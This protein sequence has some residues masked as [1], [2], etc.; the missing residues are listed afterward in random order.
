MKKLFGTD[1]IRGVANVPPMTAEMALDIGRAA[2]QVCRRHKNRRSK[3]IVGRD[4]RRSGQMLESALTAGICSMGVDV[5]LVGCVTTPG[6]AFLTRSINADAGIVVSASHNPYQDNGIK[7]FSHDGYKLPDRGEDEIER[8]VVTKEAK[9][10]SEAN[11]IGTTERIT[12]A[13]GRYVVFC[14]STFPGNLTLEGMKITIDCANG[15]AY[16]AAPM[17]FSELGAEVTPI[18][19]EPDGMNINDHCGSQDTRR[20]S[21]KVR[22]LS[23]DLGL[24]FDGDGDRIIAVDE[25]GREI[26]GDCILAIC[27]KMYKDRGWLRNNLVISTVMSNYGLSLA[28]KKLAIDNASSDV[29]DRNVLEKM[30]EKGAVVGGEPSGHLIFLNHHTSGDGII[31]AL[32][33][34][35]AIRL[36]NKPLSRL[37]LVM[38]QTPQKII[39]VDVT[40]KPP[41]GSIPGLREAVLAAETELDSRGRVLIRYSGTQSVCRVMVEG[42]T[43][44]MT[45]RL[46]HF[47]AERV[48]SR[49][50]QER[51]RRR[52]P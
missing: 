24:A 17:V 45:D 8:L 18:N 11:R 33:L 5:L 27:G 38:Q 50:Q 26:N 44:E 20:L 31:S 34:L 16:K 52:N 12:D 4:T 49:Q 2:A 15:S 9:A 30:K 36:E 3:I 14:K 23:A 25:E 19:C 51:R 1:G 46:A 7:I 39:N 47:L 40:S 28:L 6:I 35:T 13:I 32:Q 41:L 29:G 22:E 21:E 42:P 48:L 10:V 43:E 37:S